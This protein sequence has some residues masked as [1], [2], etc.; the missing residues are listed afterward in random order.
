MASRQPP[1]RLLE[2]AALASVAP[3]ALCNPHLSARCAVP[4]P[5]EAYV[6]L[7]AAHAR[8][9]AKDRLF[10]LYHAVNV[11]AVSPH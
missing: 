1:R 3:L 7:A 2:I 8:L 6:A 4:S 11:L 5:S 9:L 10:L